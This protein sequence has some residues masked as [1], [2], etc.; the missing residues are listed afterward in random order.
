MLL[1]SPVSLEL[2]GP[3]WCFPLLMKTLALYFKHRWRVHSQLHIHPS[4]LKTISR[5]MDFY[6]AQSSLSFHQKNPTSSFHLHLIYNWS[7]IHKSFCSLSTLKDGTSHSSHIYLTWIFSPALM[8][9]IIELFQT[10]QNSD[11]IT[12]SFVSSEPV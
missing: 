5:N 7:Q 12:Q 9:I 2:R 3:T 11:F 4:L 10:T 6:L 1:R 8:F